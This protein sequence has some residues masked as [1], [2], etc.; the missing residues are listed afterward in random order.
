VDANGNRNRLSV[1]LKKFDYASPGAYFITIVTQGRAAL[2]GRIV[3][4]E[5]QLNA[6]GKMVEATWLSL[7]GR[8]LGMEIGNSTIMPNHFHGIVVLHANVGAALVAA[9]ETS[10][11]EDRAGTSPAPTAPALGAIVGAF[12][13]LVTRA[14]MRGVRNDG[15]P[16]FHGR[17][18]QRNYYEHILRDE[19]DW[20]RAHRYIGANPMNWD[21][22]DENPRNKT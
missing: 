21:E 8:F 17:L 19:A 5:M 6:A 15:W 3:N 22:D 18:W 1:R 13:S 14:Y 4:G 2:F 9:H 12:K 20:D 11:L 7:P 16:A 10:P